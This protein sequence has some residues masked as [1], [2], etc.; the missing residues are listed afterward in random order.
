MKIFVPAL[1]AITVLFLVS[2]QQEP[3]VILDDV[4]PPGTDT[5]AHTSLVF[6]VVES[7]P[8]TPGD[9]IVRMVYRIQQNGEKKIKIEETYSWDQSDT[10][11]YFYSYDA[12]NHLNSIKAGPV[13]SP[14]YFPV[15]YDFTW[16]NNRLTRISVDTMGFAESF[17]YSYTAAGA[18]TIVT[19]VKTPSDDIFGPDYVLSLIHI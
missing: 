2:C 18:N 5:I 16:L 11:I 3:D 10:A 14:N 13:S 12:Q 19:C 4:T 8:Q 15:K 17:D 6:R 7:D 9:S 1:L